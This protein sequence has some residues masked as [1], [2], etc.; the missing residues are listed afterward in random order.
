[1]HLLNC[2]NIVHT[3]VVFLVS[4]G[5]WMM[6]DDGGEDI[7]LRGNIN[8]AGGVVKLIDHTYNVLGLLGRHVCHCRNILSLDVWGR[9]VPA[10]GTLTWRQVS[11]VY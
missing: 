8:A 7:I 4:T 3:N 11:S 1:M 5:T 9:T 6:R 10:I 2:V